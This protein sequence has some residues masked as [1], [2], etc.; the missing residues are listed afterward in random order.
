MQPFDLLKSRKAALRLNL[1][2]PT[3]DAMAV[4]TRSSIATCFSPAGVM[5]TVASGA[6]RFDWDPVALTPNGLFM[7]EGRVN[8]CL[9]SD[10]PG[11]ASWTKANITGTSNSQ[12]GPD[13][14]VDYGSI[15]ASLANGTILQTITVVN[16]TTYQ[17]S[18]DFKRLV[19][20]GSIQITTDNGVTWNTV[21]V[22][23]TLT[24]FTQQQVAA[25]TTMIVG[26]RIVTNADSVVMGGAMLEAGAFATSR[27]PTAGSTV[28]R[29]RDQVSIALPAPYIGNTPSAAFAVEIKPINFVASMQVAHLSDGTTSNG[30]TLTT[31]ASGNLTATF[32]VNL[33]GYTITGPLLV[34]GSVYKI[35]M[36]AGQNGGFLAV[37]GAIYQPTGG[38][39]IRQ[40]AVQYTALDL[41]IDGNGGVMYL[42]GLRTWRNL[43]LR[44][45]LSVAT[46]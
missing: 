33:A 21:A 8:L 26:V 25:G 43:V 24:R 29:N 37:N 31:D 27:I 3:L 20:T 10:A 17:F 36:S 34:A 2:G 7:E 11:N 4:F 35:A 38:I 6:V 42:R 39:V 13:G 41:G 32:L 19:G 18:V 28:T 5:T 45:H 22:T 16:G 44:E 40:P 23:S 1:L 15:T 30:F 12:T 46:Q 9:R 14:T